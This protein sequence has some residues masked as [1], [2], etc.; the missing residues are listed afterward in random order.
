MDSLK[1]GLL[2]RQQ[3]RIQKTM[4]T[5]EKFFFY[6]DYGKQSCIFKKQLSKNHD[7]QNQKLKRLE[8]WECCRGR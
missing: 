8:Q 2:K 4:I 1:S 7:P 5:K 3:K 6:K